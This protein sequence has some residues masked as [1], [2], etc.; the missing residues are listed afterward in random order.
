MPYPVVSAS[1]AFALVLIPLFGARSR[2]LRRM[3]L[4]LSCFGL[5][6]V[7]ISAGIA[8]CGGG[9]TTPKGN[10]SIDVTATAGSTAHTA[11]FSLTVQ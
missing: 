8:G 9:P 3:L 6:A 10:Y 1:A 5:L 11:T 7:L 4:T 2:K